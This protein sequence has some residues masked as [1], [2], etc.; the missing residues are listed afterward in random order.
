MRFDDQFALV[1]GAGPGL[2]AGLARGFGARGGRLALVA[3]SAASLSASAEEAR[4]GGSEPLTL[5]ADVTSVSD[6]RR[7]VDTVMEAWGQIDILVNNAFAAP[8]RRTLLEREETDLERWRETVEIGG[9]GTLL[10]CRFV[11]PHMVQAERGSIV[12]VTSMSSRVASPGRSD[13][14]SGK[15]QAHKIAQALAGELGPHGVRVNCVAPGPILSDALLNFYRTEADRLGVT[16]EEELARHTQASA[17]RRFST[18]DEVAN[19]VMFLA[20]DLASA[21]TGA[22]IDVNSGHFFTV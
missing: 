7:V 9:F 15:A 8:R 11:A 5:A 19:A 10:A 22:V 4:R 17:L 6:V 18:N 1:M 12:N 16:Y 21:I 20:S 2:G 3:R 13:Y 14:A